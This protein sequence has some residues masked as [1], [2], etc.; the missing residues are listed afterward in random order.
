MKNRTKQGLPSRNLLIFLSVH[1]YLVLLKT[2]S[3]DNA[4]REFSFAKAIMAYE[5]LYHDLQKWRAY[6]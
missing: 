5:P 3:L 1:A 2:E 4:I 6:A